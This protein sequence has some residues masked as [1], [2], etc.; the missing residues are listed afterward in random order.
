[1]PPVRKP[2]PVTEGEEGW[3]SVA[4]MLRL[5]L[6]RRWVALTLIFIALVL[7][8][9]RLGW[10]QF[11]RYQETKRNDHRISLAA[12]APP[13]GVETLSHPGAAIPERDR[14]RP[15]TVTG[16]FDAADQFVVRRRTN[17]AGNI[18][19]F[20]IT[21]LVTQDGKAVL[22][23]RGWVAPNDNDGAAFPALPKTPQGVLTLTGRL[24]PD[25]TSKLSRIRNVSGLPPRQ[26][27]LISSTEQA[28]KLAEPLLGGYVELVSTKPALTAAYQ[29]QSVAGPDSNSQSTSDAAI[30]GKGVH[31][32]YAIQWWLFALM[33][34]IG[35]VILF[36]QGLK[37]ERE[38]AASRESSKPAESAEAAV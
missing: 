16:R 34:P 21:P 4:G 5:L 3:R 6:T 2:A 7:I 37:D 29:A 26:F 20:L 1:M 31:L 13:V 38:S 12:H 36:R 18:G 35:W 30:V 11:H 17:A 22:V 15:V 8:M 25:E 28:K 24:Q 32:P 27:M 10:W 19:F 23:N 14:Y 33:L 9:Y